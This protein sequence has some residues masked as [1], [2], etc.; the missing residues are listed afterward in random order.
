MKPIATISDLKQARSQER[1]IIFLW[2]DWAIHARRS[3]IVVKR[4][5]E[6]WERDHGDCK[7]ESYRIDVGGQEGE[8]WDALFE[9]L[10]NEPEAR[11]NLI[12]GG[13]GA[14]LWLRS[15]S[16]IASVVYAA[17]A[18]C[19]KLLAITNDAFQTAR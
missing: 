13:C 10:P 4:F 6:S 16:V 2:V 8:I 5:L 12:W 11:G 9:W 7:V 19:D 17:D 15:G 3:E 14:L 18:G 1:A